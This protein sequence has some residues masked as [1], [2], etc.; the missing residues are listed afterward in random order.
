VVTQPSELRLTEPSQMRALAHPLRLRLLGRLRT[1][2]P[3]TATALAERLGVSP[4]LASYHLRQ[5][6]AHG[7]IQPAAELARDGKERWWRAAHERTSWSTAEFL[8]TP[9]RVAAEQAL[10]RE[11]GR[12]HAERAFEWVAEASTWPADWVDASDMSDWQLEVTPDE[13]RKLRDEL[14]ASIER[15]A[16]R[17]RREDS[18]RVVAILHL[19]PRRSETA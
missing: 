16:H 9:E 12:A 10:G 7:F 3:A 1:D 14:H 6:A 8:D 18:E 17:P 5:L 4:A 19:F 15:Y 13:L 11:I 2:G